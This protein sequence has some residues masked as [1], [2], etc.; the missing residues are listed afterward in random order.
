MR[1][2]AASQQFTGKVGSWYAWLG[3]AVTSPLWLLF[4]LCLLVYSL[5][6]GD[7]FDA[8]IDGPTRTRWRTPGHGTALDHRGINKVYHLKPAHLDVRVAYAQAILQAWERRR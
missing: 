7:G 5:L 8:D 1:T 3:Y 2:H 6:D 4:W